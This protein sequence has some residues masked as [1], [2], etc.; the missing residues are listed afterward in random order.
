MVDGAPCRRACRW[1][2]Q[3]EICR[4][5]QCRDQVV[6]PEGVNGGLGA[7][8]TSLS[9]LPIWSMDTLGK[10]IHEPSFLLVDL[11]WITL[12]DHMPKASA[13]HRTSTL[14]SPFQLT[15]EHSPKTDSH[16]SMTAE[17]QE[18][19]SCAMLDTS[20]QVLGDSTPK[21]PTSVALGTPPFARMEDFSRLVAPSPQASLQVVTPDATM[22]IS[23]SSPATPSLEIP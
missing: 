11:S 16:I 22:P 1:L 6:Y 10:P 4:L 19:L 2:C 17:V 15:L 7:G 14:S 8:W 18:L 20:S 12:G 9:E 21:R 13:S 3:L 5:L 23:H